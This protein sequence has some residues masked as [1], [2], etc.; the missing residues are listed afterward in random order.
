MQRRHK[1]ICFVHSETQMAEK[2]ILNCYQLKNLQYKRRII[3][4]NVAF[5]LTFS[6]YVS[7]NICTVNC[8]T[9]EYIWYNN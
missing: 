8:A 3:W 1:N 4:Q 2:L 6:N 7:E 5:S 9:M